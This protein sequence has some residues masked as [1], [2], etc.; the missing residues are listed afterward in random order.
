MLS[1]GIDEAVDRLTGTGHWI[2]LAPLANFDL[3][4]RLSPL[5]HALNV[6]PAPHIQQFPVCSYSPV[7]PPLEEQMTP[8]QQQVS[9]DSQM[10]PATTEEAALSPSVDG[11]LSA[12][13]VLRHTHTSLGSGV[14]TP[15]DTFQSFRSFQAGTI[16]D[17]E[18]SGPVSPRSGHTAS[19]CSSDSECEQASN[20]SGS[21]YSTS[22]ESEFS[23]SDVEL[24]NTPRQKLAIQTQFN[25]RDDQRMTRLQ[26][27]AAAAAQLAIPAIQLP[28]IPRPP[29]QSDARRPFSYSSI[30]QQPPRPNVN[31]FHVF[32]YLTL[33]DADM[34]KVKKNGTRPVKV[35][36]NINGSTLSH[37]EMRKLYDKHEWLSDNHINSYME[38]IDMRNKMMQT[39]GKN[40]I[41]FLNT[42]FMARLQQPDTGDNYSSLVRWLLKLRT[43][44]TYTYV[45]PVHFNQNHWFVTVVNV[46]SGEIVSVET[47]P[48]HDNTAVVH[49]IGWFFEYHWKEI[50]GGKESPTWSVEML[51]PPVAPTQSDSCSCG[52]FACAIMDLYSVGTSFRL[53]REK[54]SQ[55]NILEIRRRMAVFMDGFNYM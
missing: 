4:T 5:V 12:F 17:G 42:Q 25:G 37:A 15:N 11:G 14:N 24:V 49:K 22:D 55:R 33:S 36:F 26:A 3:S 20:E 2:Q 45:I 31:D 40:G 41:V 7:Q 10:S 48:G 38:L 28:A 53:M 50:G 54:L 23:G 9:Q 52:V 19:P 21:R 8:T 47:L 32:N 44:S 1:C 35:S 51:T 39:D 46:V 29:I 34:E 27:R 16:A 6:L 18:Q 13:E 43:P 30:I